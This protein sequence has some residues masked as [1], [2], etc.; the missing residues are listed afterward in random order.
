[1]QGQRKLTKRSPE[2][3]P[4][5]D[6]A[7]TDGGA[8]CQ[9]E[10]E[11]EGGNG[12]VLEDPELT[13]EVVEGTERRGKLGSGGEVPRRPAAGGDGDGRIRPLR[14]S[15][16]CARWRGGRGRDGGAYEVH[17]GARGRP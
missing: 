3:T 4:A 16:A 6:G 11:G 17:G 10:A 7:A 2:W 14:G 8:G 13:R 5:T 1:M 12:G 15:P 9:H